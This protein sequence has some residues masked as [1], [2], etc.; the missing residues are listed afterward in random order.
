MHLLVELESLSEF[1]HSP[2]A[3]GDHEFPFEVSGVGF[4]CDTEVVGGF[5]EIAVFDV[6]DAKPS[7]G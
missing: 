6:E 7:D 2:E 4:G 1:V 3:G 5:A